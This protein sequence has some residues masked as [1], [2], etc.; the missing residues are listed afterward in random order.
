MVAHPED[1]DSRLCWRVSTSVPNCA[2]AHRT[3]LQYL[4][5]IFIRYSGQTA[6]SHVTRSPNNPV[7]VLTSASPLPSPCTT[8]SQYRHQPALTLHTTNSQLTF[9]TYQTFTLPSNGPNLQLQ[10][11]TN[12]VPPTPHLPIARPL[13]VR[14][15][16]PWQCRELKQDHQAHS[17]WLAF[18][19]C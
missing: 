4:M 7:T 10:R 12:C 16:G 2:A 13:R 9:F 15:A 14:Q 6:A 17:Q 3:P 1:G 8:R 5:C 11:S 19:L 18:V